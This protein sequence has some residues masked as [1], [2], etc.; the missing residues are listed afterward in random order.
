[1]SLWFKK[2]VP[3][4]KGVK[5]TATGAKP[6]SAPAAQRASAAQGMAPA[7]AAR[8]LNELHELPHSQGLLSMG[9][10]AVYQVPPQFE[11]AVMAIE[12]GGKRAQILYDPVAGGNPQAKQVL[13]ALRNKLTSDQYHL[14]RDLQVAGRVLRQLA[15]DHVKKFGE[16]TLENRNSAK[17]LA[18]ERFMEW[19][20]IAVGENA[21]DIHAQITQNG[22]IVHLR[23]DGELELLR[24]QSR[25]KYT[26]SETEEAM[27]WPFNSAGARGSNSASQWSP[28]KNDYCMT[29]PIT[30]G[31]KK[32]ALR[33]QS[34]RGQQGP[35]MVARV[36][37]VDTSGSVLTYDQLGYSETQKHLMLDAANTDSGFV[38]FLGVTGSGKTTTQK[39]FVETHPG[40]GSKAIYSVEDPVEY[41][42]KGVHQI[43]IQRDIA[44]AEGSKAQ[45]LEAVAAL[46]RAD[47][48]IAI[49]G[50]IRDSATAGAGQQIVE[51]GHMALGTVHAHLLSGC[52]PRLTNEG[53]GMSRD[54]LTNPNM[55]TLLCYQALVPKVCPNCAFGRSEAL[56]FARL[57]DAERPGAAYTERNLAGILKDIDQRF[58]LDLD[59][60]R[61]KNPEGCASCRSRGTKGVTV[62]AEMLCPDREWLEWTRAGK[63]YEAMVHYRSASNGDRTSPNM[64][65][66][67]VFE[68][69]LYKSFIGEV[70]PTQCTR[71][72]TFARFE[73]DPKLKSSDRK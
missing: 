30:V 13:Q 18:K 38:I 64:M 9:Q 11:A 46:M 49:V 8:V 56:R 21:T 7:G 1:M 40:N 57:F 45:Y 69:A 68:H 47:P 63:D 39:S 73:L 14:D 65:G 23:I 5:P 71:F 3:A 27:A 33:Y 17:S 52:I 28:T 48:D 70:D 15:D 26:T 12:L 42:M 22:G 4:P 61:F 66:K 62:V 32:V 35:K 44:N 59:A 55:L 24:N 29:E 53:I 50:E 37:N 31:M 51:T 60:F 16:N 20:E 10:R 6:G 67:T 34:L 58:K 72:D 54:V 2:A 43:P 41:L 19:L 25:G 36:L